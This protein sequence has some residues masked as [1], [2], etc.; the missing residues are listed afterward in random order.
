[1]W[2]VRKWATTKYA[3]QRCN[4]STNAYIE[5]GKDQID[6]KLVHQLEPGEEPK[7]INAEIAAGL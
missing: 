5:S 1:M 4:E 7:P 2:V 3:G 6:M